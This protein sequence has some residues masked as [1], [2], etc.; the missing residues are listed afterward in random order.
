MHAAAQNV[1]DDPS[2]AYYCLDKPFPVDDAM[3]QVLLDPQQ[4]IEGPVVKYILTY[5]AH[6]GGSL[7]A[8]RRCGVVDPH[9]THEIFRE[10]IATEPASELPARPR[11][12]ATSILSGHRSDVDS[13]VIPYYAHGHWTLFTFDSGSNELLFYNSLQPDEDWP[14]PRTQY[15]ATAEHVVAEL[16]LRGQE[17]RLTRCLR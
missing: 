14:V 15:I 10:V 3:A 2:H 16:T 11:H 5:L 12:Y 6:C 17:V 13:L 4:D 8:G 9:F 7:P 1:F